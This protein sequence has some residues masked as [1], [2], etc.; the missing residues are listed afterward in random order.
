M[1]R[2]SATSPAVWAVV[3]VAISGYTVLQNHSPFLTG[4]MRAHLHA[5]T[6]PHEAQRP[7]GQGR[8]QAK[9]R[10]QRLDNPEPTPEQ[11]PTS[12][13][14]PVAASNNPATNGPATNGVT[15]TATATR[16]EAPPAA[17]S[18]KYYTITE[19]NEKKQKELADIAKEF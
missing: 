7:W 10:T 4:R 8:R 11:T 6:G 15:A 12:K 17:P 19:L 3:R 13:E 16:R 2:E 1:S 18:R 5:P 14:A 9:E